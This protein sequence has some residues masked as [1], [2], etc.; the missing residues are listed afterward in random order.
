M[1]E[2]FSHVTISSVLRARSTVCPLTR[3]LHPVQIPFTTGTTGSG[4]LR[5]RFS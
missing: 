3:S 4:K 2:Q 5:R 1:R